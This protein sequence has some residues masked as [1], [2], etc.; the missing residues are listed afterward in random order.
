MRH[1]L[2]PERADYSARADG[3]DRPPVAHAL[4]DP[5]SA[6]SAL[7]DPFSALRAPKGSFSA[8]GSR[9]AARRGRS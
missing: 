6:L 2:A 7:K 4:K 3:S 5:F 9:R 8:R 1:V